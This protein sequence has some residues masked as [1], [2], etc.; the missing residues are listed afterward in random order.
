MD[1]TTTTGT[2]EAPATGTHAKPIPLGRP[3]HVHLA[4]VAIANLA[5]GLVL[6]GA[7]LVAVGLTR[8]PGEI[9]LLNA[10]FWLPWLLLGIVAGL[11]V[12]R[13]DRRNLRIAGIAVRAVLLLGL[14]WAAFADALTMPLLIGAT[15]AYGV[16][17]VFVDLAG[18]AMVP[19]VAPRARLSAANGR[20]MGAET[21]MNNFVGGPIAGALLV[22]GS[23]WILGAGAVL[24]VVFVLVLLAGLR[25]SYRPDAALRPGAA[26]AGVSA[27]VGNHEPATEGARGHLA[28]IREGLAFLFTHPVIRPLVIG[29]SLMNMASTAYFSIFVLWVV[30]EDSAVG[31]RAEAFGLLLAVLAVGAVLG[32]VC[33]EPLQRWIEEV[34]LLFVVWTIQCLLLVVPVLV[35][36]VPAIAATLFVMGFS[37]MIG[38]VVSQTVRQRLIPMDARPGGRRRGDARLRADACGGAARGCGG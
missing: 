12:D 2:T 1:T 4:S 23:G 36:T 30:G 22:L 24:C 26:T 34:P 9:S 13:S 3:F 16:T 10:V 14:A 29:A 33:A 31:L 5:D 25:G 7:P 32:S 19:Q 28:R 35:P 18:S 17:A 27:V 20:V 6:V 8:S 15:A 21:V 11:V 37:N 38:N